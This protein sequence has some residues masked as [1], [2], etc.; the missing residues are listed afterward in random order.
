MASNNVSEGGTAAQITVYWLLTRLT[1]PNGVI[2]KVFLN[3]TSPPSI[4]LYIDGTSSNMI[5]RSR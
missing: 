4:N 3:A 2:P 5:M 1:P